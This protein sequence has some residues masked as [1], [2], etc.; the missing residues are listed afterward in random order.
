[1][2]KK[3]EP[4]SYIE[5]MRRLAHAGV[6]GSPEV[7][8]PTGY[9][10]D[11]PS[12]QKRVDFLMGIVNRTQQTA[13]QMLF[14]VMYDIESNKVRREIAKYLE[15]KGCFRIQKSIFLASLDRS[16]C[17]QIKQDLAEVQA[18]YDNNDSVIVCPVATDEIRAM[19]VIGQKVDID[20]ITQAKNT[21]FF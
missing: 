21:L 9:T 13:T 10:E 16:V 20:I 6:R 3:K 7:N 17:E 2:R 8:R 15:D 1:M 12:L 19:K 18:L 4:L 14:F 5:I 11:M